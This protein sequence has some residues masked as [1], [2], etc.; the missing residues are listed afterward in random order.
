M[1]INLE[2]PYSSLY[3]KGYLRIS[4]D[5]RKRVD[6]FNSNTDRTTISYARYVMCVNLGYVLSKDYEVDH[7]DRDKNNDDISN[8]QV[9]SVEEHRQKNSKE[10]KT[11]RAFTELV[12]NNCGKLFKRESRAVKYRN[13]YCDNFCKWSKQKQ[14]GMDE[15]FKSA[16]EFYASNCDKV[17]KEFGVPAI[18]ERFGVSSKRMYKYIK[19]HNIGET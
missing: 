11:G 16:L 9:L 6:L 3:R 7:I 2:E 14:E 10:M 18:S 19:K 17:G 5:G 8:L 4:K 13:Y 12:C 1:V 15:S